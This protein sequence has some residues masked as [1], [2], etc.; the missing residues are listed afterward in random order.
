MESSAI[1]RAADEALDAISAEC[2]RIF[3]LF[4][5]GN[6]LRRSETLEFMFG[7]VG[8]ALMEVEFSLDVPE[9][10][11]SFSVFTDIRRGSRSCLVISC[12]SSS[13]TSVT[14]SPSSSMYVS[15]SSLSGG[16]L[17]S[18]K[19]LSFN[20]SMLRPSLSSA[21]RALNRL[22]VSPY[23]TYTVYRGSRNPISTDKII[24]QRVHKL[25]PTYI[26]GHKKI[27]QNNKR[28]LYWLNR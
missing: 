1:S 25:V 11:L 16:K 2:F 4:D 6:D 28:K 22:S 26:H 15:V 18:L 24:H 21:T 7:N 20:S 13:S 23:L 5:F 10:L 8:G 3:L 19:I 17:K 9:D 14:T 27:N 12:R